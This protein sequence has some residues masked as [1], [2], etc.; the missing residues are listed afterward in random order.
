MSAQATVI[1]EQS[2]IFAPAPVGGG[3]AGRIAGCARALQ[4][5]MHALRKEPGPRQSADRWIEENYSYLVFQVRELQEILSQRY[6]RKLKRA[7]A[8]GS[9]PR[10]YSIAARHLAEFGE[11]CAE[12]LA[13]LEGAVREQQSLKLIELWAYGA[14]LKLALIGRLCANL[15]SETTL[16]ASIRALRAL[17]SASW[18]DF[19]E[20]V[21]RVEAVLRADPA[22]VYARMDFDT[23]DRYRQRVEQ[24]ARWSGRTEAE[25]AEAAVASAVAG[26]SARGERDITAHVGYYLIG[27]G[28]AKFCTAVGCR[29]S[30][31]A[32]AARAIRQWPGVFYA[33]ALAIVA[34]LL[35]F[36]FD[37]LSDGVPIWVWVLLAIPVSQ[38]ALEIVNSII[39]HVVKPQAMPSMNFASAIPESCQTMVVVPSLLLSSEVAARLV[40]DLEIRYLANRDPNL[41]FGLLTDFPDARE[42]ETEADSVLQICVNGIERLNARYGVDGSGPFYL[43]HR[44]RQWNASEAKWIGYE[45]KR[46]KINTLN[47][48]LLGRG[49]GFDVTLGDSSRFAGV[50]YVITLD[51]DTQLPRDSASK[52]I[53]AM[54]HP[55]N[56]PVV[57]EATGVVRRG[58]GL[59]RP[60]VSTSMVSAGRSLFAQIFSG[61]A[62][63]DPY[64][65]T[66]S[67]VYQDLFERTSYTGKGIYDPRT[68]EAAVGERFPENAI[69]SHDLIEGEH[70]RVGFCPG[71]ELVEDYP[72]SYHAF[73]KRKHRWVRGDWQLLPWLFGPAAKNPLDLLAR[74][75]LF[76]NLRRSLVEITLVLLLAAG[77]IFSNHPLQWTLLVL[78]LIQ[79]PAY[80]DILLSMTCAPQSRLWRAF[81]Q[82]LG[83]QFVRRHRDTLLNLIFLPHQALLMCDAIVRTLARRFITHRNLLEWETMAQ[84]QS[85][86]GGVGVLGAYFYVACAAALGLLVL[87]GPRSLAICLICELWIAAPL[88]AHWLN[89]APPRPMALSET[90]RGFLRETALRTWRYFADHQDAGHHWLIPDNVQQDPP[91]TAHRISP[92][93]LGLQLTAQ[94]AAHDFGYLTLGELSASLRR[95]FHSMAEMPKHRG[96][97]F[98]WYDTADLQPIAPKYVSSVDS[99]NLA[100]S[101]CALRQGA[102]GLK[103]QP[104]IGPHVL[105]GIRD[106]VLT[107]RR[108]LP[109]GLRSVSLVRG[110][111]SLLRQLESQPADLFAWQAVLT[112][113]N[114]LTAKIHHSVQRSCARHAGGRGEEKWNELAYW[115]DRLAERVEQALGELYRLAPWLID[116]CASELRVNCCN[117]SFAALM[118]EL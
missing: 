6:V 24:L 89:M 107:I 11:A 115:N 104:W 114:G 61:M 103:E 22:G 67:D 10:I 113:V 16:A 53:A 111:T 34:A 64:A 52:M 18:R 47:Q 39:S 43:F 5:R 54:A 46:G 25:V 68:F 3:I 8:A 84:S 66:V 28:A 71:A 82:D 32:L 42:R 40:E 56:R 88:I 106:H 109:Y 100:A 63:F 36:G 80:A 116:E 2:G 75:K 17:E 110:I 31:Q 86:P 37:R 117:P 14:M 81:L 93:N 23:R 20:S 58:Y 72:A 55:L 15:H 112:E 45:R 91:M 101:L 50:R 4:E 79:I 12:D 77:W 85:S 78:A 74:W 41:L 102:R 13:T 76:D 105:A 94:L 87:V 70:V 60:R 49:D 97:F 7:G 1:Q 48:L 38:A 9:E 96:H 118:A 83:G 33:S 51:A 62:G 44:G 99:G 21:S 35:G 30:L 29:R 95:I 69:L 27:A 90:S 19:V 59:I 57:D 98:N 26:L 73:S 92:T 108:L 65:I